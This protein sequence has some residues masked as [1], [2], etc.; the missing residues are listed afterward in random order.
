VIIAGDATDEMF[1]RHRVTDGH[2]EKGARQ[3][4]AERDESSCQ[5]EQAAKDQQVEQ[6]VQEMIDA[7]DAELVA[8]K[9]Q[10]IEGLR[11]AERAHQQELQKAGK[12]AY[13]QVQVEFGRARR[14]MVAAMAQMAQAVVHVPGAQTPA[15]ADASEQQTVETR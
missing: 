15:A 6:R 11:R 9:E 7:H 14:S 4:P 5:K 3:A 8:M 2:A 1:E 13:E 10:Q 12:A